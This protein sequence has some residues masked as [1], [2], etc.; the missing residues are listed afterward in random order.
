MEAE[1]RVGKM[2][3]VLEKI[4]ECTVLSHHAHIHF[5]VLGFM[6]SGSKRNNT[7]YIHGL[8]N[9]AYPPNGTFN[10]TV[11]VLSSYVSWSFAKFLSDAGSMS[12]GSFGSEPK[13]S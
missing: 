4:K 13:G 6:Y 7:I 10:E 9:W 12:R 3:F 11:S 5:F 1:P 8:E 2:G